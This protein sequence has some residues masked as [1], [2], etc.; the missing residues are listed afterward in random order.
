MTVMEKGVLA[1]ANKEQREKLIGLLT[2]AY[3]AEL[4]T[5]MNYLASATNLDGVRAREVA[6]I[7]L[8]DA[9]GD[10]LVHAERF[11]NRIKELYGVVPGSMSF[12]PDQSYIQP[13]EH[14]TDVVHV[15]KGVIAAEKSAVAL[16]EEIV[17]FTD[18]FDLV[19]QDMVIDILGDEQG[20]LRM[21]EG[22]LREYE[23]DGKA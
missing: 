17:D 10:E 22:F 2:K 16:Y 15:I 9:K 8:E 23:A 3:W 11:A 20:H 1:E 4:E 5:V 13:P 6:E 18:D 14:Q 7:L 12:K 19:T 21:F